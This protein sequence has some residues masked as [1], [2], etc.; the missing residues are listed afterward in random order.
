MKYLFFVTFCWLCKENSSG[1]GF[2]ACASECGGEHLAEGL[3]I[4][5]GK[6]DDDVLDEHKKVWDYVLRANTNKNVAQRTCRATSSLRVN[7]TKNPAPLKTKFF[8]IIE[9]I[10]LSHVIIGLGCVRVQSQ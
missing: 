9:I 3:P 4:T 10:R 6:S 7:P 1:S 5:D 8:V 2:C